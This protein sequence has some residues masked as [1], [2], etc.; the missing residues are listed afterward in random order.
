VHVQAQQGLRAEH[1]ALLEQRVQQHGNEQQ[2]SAAKHASELGMLR[3]QHAK[4]LADHKRAFE[5]E[6]NELR[7]EHSVAQKSAADRAEQDKHSAL[8]ALREELTTA[9]QQR[10][11]ETEQRLTAAHGAELGKQ[12]EQHRSE[13]AQLAKQ[14][15]D[16]EASLAKLA[17]DSD[18][19]REEAEAR[20]RAVVEER[21]QL[22]AR[23]AGLA[24]QLA[25]AQARSERDHELLDRVRKAMA[26]GLG[27]LEEQKHEPA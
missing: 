19:A 3:E 10:V 2:A 11:A 24:T 21:D 4:S 6:Q 14:L 27:L 23:G 20:L 15:S 1:A 25:R 12:V 7:E 18:K 13:L 26:I 5:D 9:A 8:E 16:S 17:T 22:D